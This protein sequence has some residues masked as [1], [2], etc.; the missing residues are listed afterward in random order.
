MS[1][2]ENSAG[3]GAEDPKQLSLGIAN[4]IE[5]QPASP[6]TESQAGAHTRESADTLT[7]E[8][9]WMSRTRRRLV[10]EE[11]DP[12]MVLVRLLEDARWAQGRARATLREAEKTG[13]RLSVLKLFWSVRTELVKVLQGL[14]VLPRELFFAEDEENDFDHLPDQVAET[15]SGLLSGRLEPDQTPDGHLAS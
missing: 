12:Q 2:P 11:T 14:G 5:T 9:A 15:I 4:F 8:A 3:P 7:D 13:D 10:S 1:G 6:P